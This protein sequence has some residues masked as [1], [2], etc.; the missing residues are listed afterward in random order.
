MNKIKL[1]EL[2]KYTVSMAMSI[3]NLD[4]DEEN[5]KKLLENYDTNLQLIASL[6]YLRD[7]DATDLPQQI[8]KADELFA[9][10]SFDYDTEIK[11]EEDYALCIITLIMAV[12]NEIGA[13]SQFK[14]NN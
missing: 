11:T 1:F 14:K 9:Y 13:L 4:V 10:S 2:L 6:V 12:E 3:S 8:E 7:Y 5:Y